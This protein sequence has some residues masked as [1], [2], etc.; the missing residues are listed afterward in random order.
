MLK[1]AKRGGRLVRA[2]P[3][4]RASSVFG[5]LGTTLT[6]FVLIRISQDSI[7]L[8]LSA[9]KSPANMALLGFAALYLLIFK[10][11]L[12]NSARFGMRQALPA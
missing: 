6:E 2:R 3:P 10:V 7:H 12:S 11:R 1:C 9:R 4:G 8:L 5:L